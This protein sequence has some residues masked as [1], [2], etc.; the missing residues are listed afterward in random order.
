MKSDLRLLKKVGFNYIYN[1]SNIEELKGF[2]LLVS[3]EELTELQF[4]KYTQ[5]IPLNDGQNNFVFKTKIKRII[6]KCLGKK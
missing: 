6:K 5:D 3:K 2:I 1:Y 4:E